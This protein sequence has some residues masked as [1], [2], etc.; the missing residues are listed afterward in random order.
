MAEPLPF[1]VPPLPWHA[2]VEASAR[3]RPEKSAAI[4]DDRPISYRALWERAL[5]VAG[6]LRGL[7]LRKGDRVCLGLY[8]R[9][10]FIE[11]MIAASWLGAIAAPLNPSYKAEE[12]HH[13]LQDSGATIAIL[14]P[15]T[16]AEV[17]RIRE[18][19]SELRTVVVVGEPTEGALGVSA[20]DG[21]PPQAVEVNPEDLLV[22]LYS[23]GTT[24]RPKGVMLTHRNLLASH[25][26][27]I[28]AGRVT[29][30]DVSLLFV[31]VCHVYGLNLMGGALV[32]GAT[33]ILLPGYDLEQCLAFTERY[34]V[35]LF[36]ATTS[37]LLDLCRYP[38]LHE[39][40]LSSIRY[41]N[42][43]GA[44]LP[45]EVAAKVEK[46]AR[47]RVA[48]GYGMTEAP[49]SGSRVPG[50]E[51]RV[52]NPETGRPCAPGEP[53]E[54]V[55][56]GPH[57]MK[58][59]WRDPAL[60]GEALQ[61]GWLHTG[62]LG[63]LDAEGRLTILSRKK[64]MIKYKGFAV[65]PLELE[66]VLLEHPAVADCAVVAKPHPEAGEIPKAFVVLAPGARAR[67]EELMA[68]VRGRVAEYKRIRE[69]G[70]VSEIPRNHA[71]KILKTRLEALAREDSLTGTPPDHNG[72]LG[73]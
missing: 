45:P 72:I 28:H 22:L 46:L 8:N 16:W 68:F 47:I 35:T 30:Q 64:E 57:V 66:G 6:G 9:P 59:Y 34:G 3:R 61:E 20:L 49:I 53:G 21:E 40:N 65:S 24:G 67:A 7:G 52:V 33:Q 15:R 18:R 44:P 17:R 54:I 43:G 73:S 14:E 4:F 2:L 10:E 27:Y 50:E 5:R 42:S 19:L 55:I 51:R 36:Y 25:L 1:S 69:V 62:D 38:K 12:C 71:G 48:N 29:D 60:T 31:P 58:G 13:Q 32:A 70:F 63:V 23:S 39:F 26:Q 41:I 11:G 56:R 37:V